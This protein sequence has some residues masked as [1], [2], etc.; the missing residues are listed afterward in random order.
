[1]LAYRHAFH[2]GN[3][4][5]VLKHLVY[6]QVLRYMM[7]KPKGVWLIDTHAGAGGYL[8]K[9]RKSVQTQGHRKPEYID[10]IARLWGRTDMPEAVTA[11]VDCVRA[12]NP[13]GPL[14]YYPGS[15][16]LAMQ[17][18]RPKDQ[19]RLF[20]LHPTDVELLAKHF[21]DHRHVE[22]HRTDGFGAL[23]AL[24]PPATRR[25]LVLVDPAY[26]LRAD[27]GL[28]VAA[29]RDAMKRF[30]ECVLMVWYPHIARVEARQL[31]QRLKACAPKDWLHVQLTVRGPNTADDGFG[32]VGSG[33]FVF[34][35][36]W[37]L[38]DTLK[39]EMPWLAET[40]AQD[41]QAS[42]LLEQHVV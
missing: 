41:E 40:L 3:H 8:L 1:M 26:E 19:M 30:P 9:G 25:A 2:A 38:H 42:W 23:K 11:F 5:D 10:G 37:T 31:P 36:P 4:A 39:A 27:Y 28:L 21:A 16:M 15:P 29:V 22:V 12:V 18:M 7:E 24:L 20:E 6:V 32:L 34:N 13:E 17:A 14:H 33:V 35:P